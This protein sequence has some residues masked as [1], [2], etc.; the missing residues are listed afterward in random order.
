MSQ[1]QNQDDDLIII[2]ENDLND[3][4]QAII[5]E[6]KTSEA[7]NKTEN[8]EINENITN[9]E[10]NKED[11]SIDLNFTPDEKIEEKTDSNRPKENELGD[12][13]LDFSLDNLEDT[14]TQ[15]K[16]AND[17]NES[18]DSL[19][20]SLENLESKNDEKNKEEEVVLD[21]PENNEDELA[22][23]TDTQENEKNKEDKKEDIWTLDSIINEAISKLEARKEIIAESINQKDDLIKE[24]KSKINSLEEE[25]A[26][27]EKNK[28]KLKNEDTKILQ[29]IKSLEKMK[30]TE[31]NEEIEKKDKK[32]SS[33]K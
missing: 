11:S 25:K 21:I 28:E 27:T 17:G 31:T 13:F 33:K 22:A 5:A 2:E 10:E 20:L 23:F 7:E 24:I 12:N 16:K 4:D 26:Q 29:N 18:N 6:E 15:E 9:I 30:L 14:E 8:L 32:T 19:D 1:T 3:L